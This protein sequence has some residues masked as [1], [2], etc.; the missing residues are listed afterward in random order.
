MQTEFKKGDKVL[1]ER[2][3]GFCYLGEAILE[4]CTESEHCDNDDDGRLHALMIDATGKRCHCAVAK[5]KLISSATNNMG[6]LTKTQEKHLDKDSQALIQVGVLTPSLGIDNTTK[7]LEML[8]ELNRKGLADAARAELAEKTVEAKY[9]LLLPT[10]QYI[11]EN[12]NDL[13]IT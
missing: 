11:Y 10:A 4:L 1:L 7:T 6:T 3:N 8:V 9:L 12:T 2:G 5:W 13:F